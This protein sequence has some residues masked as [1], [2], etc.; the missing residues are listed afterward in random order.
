MNLVFPHG[1][2]GLAGRDVVD[3]RRHIGIPRNQGFGQRLRQFPVLGGGDDVDQPFVPGR[4]MAQHQEPPESLVALEPVGRRARRF[5][6]LADIFEDLVSQ[7]RKEQTRFRIQHLVESSRNV[8]PDGESGIQV[9]PSHLLGQEPPPVRAGEFHLVPVFKDAVRRQGF[10]DRHALD[11]RDVF[12]RFRHVPAL[13]FDLLFVD[14]KLPF[15]AAAIAAVGAGG[16]HP[17]R[18]RRDQ[19]GDPGLGVVALLFEH[20]G[21]HPV[22]GNG[23]VHE[24]RHAVDFR[25]AP[26]AERHVVD[27]QLDLLPFFDRHTRS[28]LD[29]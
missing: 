17:V 18:R 21:P 10:V 13:V 24:H 16:R 23:A 25:K 1:D 7:R 19:F 22:S 3:H 2:A 26:A 29:S 11:Q 8:Q 14:Q 6:V 28:L 5:H 27:V 12:Q 15:A 4:G 9:A 20:P